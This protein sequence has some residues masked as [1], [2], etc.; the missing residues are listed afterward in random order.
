MRNSEATSDKSNVHK[1]AAIGIALQQQ[2]KLAVATVAILAWNQQSMQYE[3]AFGASVSF[4]LS[5]AG[6]P[7]SN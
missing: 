2:N 6:V 4:I 5:A 3:T 1:S 7:V